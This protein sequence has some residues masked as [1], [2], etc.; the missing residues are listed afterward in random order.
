[1]RNNELKNTD[2]I[3]IIELISNA[4]NRAYKAVNQELG[5]LYWEI[6]SFMSEKVISGVWG[7]GVVVQLATYI[8]SKYP[9]LRGFT[10]RG[11]Y[12]MKQFFETY[13]KIEKVSTLLTQLNW[14]NHLKFDCS[15]IVN[16][17]RN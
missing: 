15:Q 9:N 4:Q 6:G 14:S 3:H 8:Q 10:K 7:E 12:R 11:L 5:L 17:D 1:M 16:S 13:Q 2:F